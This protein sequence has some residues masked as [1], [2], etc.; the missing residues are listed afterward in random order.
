MWRMKGDVEE[1]NDGFQDCSKF[2]KFNG[3]RIGS[4]VIDF[5][6]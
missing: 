6:L 4:F 3:K 5:N 1:I 2:K